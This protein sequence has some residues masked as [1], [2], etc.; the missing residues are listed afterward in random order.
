MS[1][2]RTNSKKERMYRVHVSLYQFSTLNAQLFLTFS[3]LM[4]SPTLS[5]QDTDFFS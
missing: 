4:E 5:N 2:K 3:F 1:G